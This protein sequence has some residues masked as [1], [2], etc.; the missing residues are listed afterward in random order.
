MV[1]VSHKIAA[2]LLFTFASGFLAAHLVSRYFS[3]LVRGLLCPYLLRRYAHIETPCRVMERCTSCSRSSMA[4]YRS[5]K[6]IS[7]EL[8]RLLIERLDWKRQMVTYI[9]VWLDLESCLVI[10]GST[11]KSDPTSSWLAGGG[12]GRVDGYRRSH[13]Q[14][15]WW[16]SLL[17]QMVVV[18]QQLL[19]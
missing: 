1:N 15:T 6:H 16:R 19:P 8:W 11:N 7:G 5:R 9:A 17:A 10:M 2:Q 4:G 12:R 13:L 14:S 18:P 3:L